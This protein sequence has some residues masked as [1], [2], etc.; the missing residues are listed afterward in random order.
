[1]SE[2]VLTTDKL[3]EY[4][5]KVLAYRACIDCWNGVDHLHLLV[6]DKKTMHRNSIYI[7]T[8]EKADQAFIDTYKD[9]PN[10]GWEYMFVDRWTPVEPTFWMPMV[11]KPSR[12]Y[13]GKLRLV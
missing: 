2:W 7:A 6:A 12:T 9:K 5:I 10:S 11:E 8:Y 3:P 13:F 1:M 4:G